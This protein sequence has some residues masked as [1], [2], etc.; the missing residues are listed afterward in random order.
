MSLAVYVFDVDM[1]IG[2]LATQNRLDPLGNGFG[3]REAGMIGMQ[4]EDMV[5]V[6]PGFLVSSGSAAVKQQKKRQDQ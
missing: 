2:E 5:N 4:D 1:N 6:G 3:T